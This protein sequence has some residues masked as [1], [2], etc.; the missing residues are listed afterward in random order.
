MK[1]FFF[2][3]LIFCIGSAMWTYAQQNERV[4]RTPEQEAAKHTEMMRRD[5]QLST[6]QIDTIYRLNLK[7]AKARRLATSRE[8]LFTFIEK[9]RQELQC[10]LTQSQFEQYLRHQQSRH[11]KRQ[12]IIKMPL[13]TVG[14]G[15]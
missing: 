5:L 2:L 10:I 11:A 12:C 3:C 14:S 8:E 4:Q 9:K 1:R 6:E 7:Y 13:D 15:N